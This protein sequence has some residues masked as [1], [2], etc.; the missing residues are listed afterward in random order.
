MKTKR[1]KKQMARDENRVLS[2]IAKRPGLKSSEYLPLLGGLSM[3]NWHRS[4]APLLDSG[5]VFKIAGRWFH[6]ERMPKSVTVVIDS[7]EEPIVAAI[8]AIENEIVRLEASK[9]SMEIQMT[10]LNAVARVLE[11]L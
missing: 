3:N 1:T 2:M 5:D 10:E 6:I 4:T 11:S 7:E 8:R 9:T